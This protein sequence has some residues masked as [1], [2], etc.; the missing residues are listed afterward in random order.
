M[1]SIHDLTGRG[2]IGYND[3]YS[4][5]NDL[6][7]TA[8]L[9]LQ[10]S[11]PSNFPTRVVRSN[12]SDDSSLVDGYRQYLP[13]QFNDLPKNRGELWKISVFN[14]LLYFHM[15]DSILRTKGKQTMQ[16]GDGSDAFI[17]SGDIFAQPPDE[18]VQTD[19]GHGGSQSQWAT[20][21]TNYGYFCMNQKKDL[22]T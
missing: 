18:L 10:V 5:V 3:D 16:L 19:S 2:N 6:G 14:N 1:D 22:C 15:E 21:V 8:P 13:N 11:Q 4:A 17:G 7:H 9:P 12:K 20:T